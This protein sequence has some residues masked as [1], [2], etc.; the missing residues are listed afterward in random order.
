MAPTEI[1][2]KKTHVGGHKCPNARARDKN[3]VEC[4][5]CGIAGTLKMEGNQITVTFSEEEQK[6]S[7][8]TLAGLKEHRDELR[9]N[10]A[11]FMRRPD[12]DELSK[13]VAQYKSKQYET[14]VLPPPRNQRV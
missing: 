3:L 10:V 8:L 9:G 12:K 11:I 6:R 13:R 2:G 1:S 7:R 4:P 14:L 5:I